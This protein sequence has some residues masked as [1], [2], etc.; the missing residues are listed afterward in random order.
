LHQ[1]RFVWPKTHDAV[2]ALSQGQ[3]QWLVAGADWQRLSAS[4]KAEWQV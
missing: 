3:W 2:F 4:P 1:G